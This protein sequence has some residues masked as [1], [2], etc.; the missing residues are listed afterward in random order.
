MSIE[1]ANKIWMDGKLVDWADANVHILTH[2]LHYGTGVL[3][4]IRFYE[5]PKGTGVFRLTDHMERLV[6]SSKIMLLD[7]PYS[8]PE[9]VDATKALLRAN[10]IAS[11]YIRPLVYRGYGE[12]GLNPLPTPTSVSIASW[13]WGAYLGDDTINKGIRLH[14]SSWQRI[15]DN[16]LPPTAKTTSNY[17]NSALAKV[18]A[19]R[20][21]FDDGIMLN[22][23]GQVAEA[24]AMNIFIVRDGAIITPP[25]SSGALRGLRRDSVMRVASDLGYPVHEADLVRS[26]LYLADEMF[27]VGTATEVAA[28]RSVDDREIG[29]PGP[30]TRKIHD[31]MAD[32]VRGKVDEYSEWVELV[33]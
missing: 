14:V 24:S 11:G 22:S 21:G 27:V 9:L 33:D 25:L 4:G 18:D 8:V 13:A 12:M 23:R 28:V 16:A 2:A 6:D 15:N 7:V 32:V 1:P 31:F 20:A 5:T 29:E 30:I 17:M 3:E 19:L 10:G 26:D